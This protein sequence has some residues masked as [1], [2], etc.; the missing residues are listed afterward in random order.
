MQHDS[1]HDINRTE[2]GRGK[3]KRKQ[4][5]KLKKCKNE[6]GAQH[7]HSLTHS[8]TQAGSYAVHVVIV[9]IMYAFF[10]SS[11]F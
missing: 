8:H 1:K 4:K 9:V 5:A 7:I 2:G 11:H 10:I 3:T 6:I